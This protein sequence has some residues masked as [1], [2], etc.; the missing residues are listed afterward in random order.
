MFAVH[1]EAVWGGPVV[2]RYWT[3]RLKTAWHSGAL[4]FRFSLR[5]LGG[6]QAAAIQTEQRPFSEVTTTVRV[7]SKR[8]DFVAAISH[9]QSLRRQLQLRCWTI[10][11]F[12]YY[13]TAVPSET[14]SSN[15]L[16]GALRTSWAILG[17][18]FAVSVSGWQA[19]SRCPLEIALFSDFEW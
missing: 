2:C 16:A 7:V 9:K 4:I 10:V 1:G 12:L 19:S 13:P 5:P 14:R 8:V 15:I 11:C 6:S 17:T 18:G 3:R